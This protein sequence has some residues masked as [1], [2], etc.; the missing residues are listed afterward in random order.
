MFFF[1]DPTHMHKTIQHGKSFT[2]FQLKKLLFI[3]PFVIVMLFFAIFTVQK[4]EKSMV[5]IK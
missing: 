5:E 2:W 3:I 1:N 4:F